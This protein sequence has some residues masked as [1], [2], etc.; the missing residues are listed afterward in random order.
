MHKTHTGFGYMTPDCLPPRERLVTANGAPPLILPKAAARR[1]ERFII[2]GNTV[3]GTSTGDKTSN[4]FDAVGINAKASSTS[5]S[6]DMLISKTNGAPKWYL[7]FEASTQYTFYFDVY[8][9][10]NAV[11][12]VYFI[13]VYTDG[14]K[15]GRMGDHTFTDNTSHYIAV[16]T[17]DSGKTISYI[18]IPETNARNFGVKISTAQIAR[19]KY[20]AETLPEYEPFGYKLP[21]R[22]VSP[23][24]DTTQF[25]IFT[26]TPLKTGDT[27]ESDAASIP[28]LFQG[29]N[30]IYV[31]T[32]VPPSSLEISYFT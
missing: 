27:L 29:A 22:F 23:S 13:I 12:R 9:M 6:G 20:S 4:L 32:A 3:D 21:I 7:P 18:H 14:T 24:G 11:N 31:D 28:E 1:P 26:S 16:F 15:S 2:S 10:Q 25:S 8:N 19:G 5:I 30:T 17:S